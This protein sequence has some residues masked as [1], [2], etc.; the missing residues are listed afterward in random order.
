LE[1]NLVLS[2]SFIKPRDK[3]DKHRDTI[4]VEGPAGP[5]GGLLTLEST[6]D[7]EPITTTTATSQSEPQSIL[8]DVLTDVTDEN[9]IDSD[10]SKLK[11]TLKS[12]SGRK[13]S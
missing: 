9:S 2:P 13:H 4:V 3:L 10:P 1:Y 11:S 8:T 12:T 6:L 5:I 7:P